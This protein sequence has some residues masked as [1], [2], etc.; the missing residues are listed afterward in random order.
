MSGR[1]A[2]DVDGSVMMPGSF[3][4][5]RLLPKNLPKNLRLPPTVL[6]EAE[7]FFALDLHDARVL[8]YDFDRAEA[9]PA[10]CVGD[11]PQ[12]FVARL[13]PRIERRGG[14]SR[15]NLLS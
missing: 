9:H 15:L 14:L 10:D 3:P 7:F 8:D 12:D 4:G 5:P 11:A 1:L 2:V 6:V 13:G